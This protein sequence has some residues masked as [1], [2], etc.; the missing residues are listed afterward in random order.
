MRGRDE[1]AVH[2]RERRQ[3]LV[4]L[5]LEGGQPPSQSHVRVFPG[6]VVGRVSCL[7]RRPLG[8]QREVLSEFLVVGRAPAHALDCLLERLSRDRFH[9]VLV[10]AHVDDVHCRLHAGEHHHLGVDPAP[11][12]SFE[13]LGTGEARHPPVQQH[14]VDGGIERLEGLPPAVGGP[15]VGVV[16]EPLGVTVRERGLVVDDQYGR[17]GRSSHRRSS[18]L[19]LSGLEDRRFVAHVQDRRQETGRGRAPNRTSQ[20]EKDEPGNHSAST[21]AAARRSVRR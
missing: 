15:D 18:V 17:C 9:E 11:A 5:S 1:E 3:R 14:D 7:E 13:N 6:E 19:T 4:E 2:L 16:G 20:G 12:D 21:R 10:E 8:R